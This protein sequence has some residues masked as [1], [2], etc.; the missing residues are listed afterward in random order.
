[1]DTRD[2]VVVETAETKSTS[3]VNDLNL[4][5]E[6]IR[7]AVAK[8]YVILAKVQEYQ[9]KLD[10]SDS[11]RIAAKANLVII[12]AYKDYLSNLDEED[13]ERL[14]FVNVILINL[15]NIEKI[16]ENSNN[17]EHILKLVDRYNAYGDELNDELVY[18][19]RELIKELLALIR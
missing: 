16:L 4:S 6:D 9:L 11:S 17:D 19:I 7:N 2:E 12:K 10:V 5:K 8:L 13:K 14:K 3:F 18:K 1:M 15:A